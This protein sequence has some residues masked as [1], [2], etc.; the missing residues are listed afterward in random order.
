MHGTKEQSFLVHTS[1][2]S[3]DIKMHLHAY[4]ML[5]IERML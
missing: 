1:H 3:A 5:H 2:S 4:F